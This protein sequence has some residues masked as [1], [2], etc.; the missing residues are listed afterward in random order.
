[1][2]DFIGTLESDDEVPQLDTIAAPPAVKKQKR[3]ASS[4]KEI[5][6]NKRRR[7]VLEEQVDVPEVNEEFTGE[8]AF[9]GLGG[10]YNSHKSTKGDIWVS[11]AMTGYLL[12]R[13]LADARG[14]I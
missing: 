8:F 2:S 7:E 3:K 1:M 9:D 14:R 11:Y 10:G 5:K 13:A 12:C 4:K 6:A